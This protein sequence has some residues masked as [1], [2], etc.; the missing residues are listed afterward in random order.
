MWTRGGL[1]FTL[2]Y[3]LFADPRLNEQGICHTACN[4]SKVPPGCSDKMNGFRRDLTVEPAMHA[5]S[6]LAEVVYHSL[7]ASQTKHTDLGRDL[8]VSLAMQASTYYAEEVYY[9]L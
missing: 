2:L 8:T 6:Y 7:Q 3:F 5:S 1:L 9:S 4:V